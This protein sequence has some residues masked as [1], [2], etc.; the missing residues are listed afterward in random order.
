MGDV[1]WYL[2][3]LVLLAGFVYYVAWV[4]PRRLCIRKFEHPVRGVKKPIR[5]VAIGDL[6]PNQWHWPA[7]RLAEAFDQARSYDPDLVVWLG[8]YY[9]SLTGT[10]S[11]ILE[12]LPRLRRWIVQK[13]PVMEEIAYEM[14][15]LKP[16]LGA[17]SVLGNHDWGWSG[18]LTRESLE[19]HGIPVLID[20]IVVIDDEQ[21]DQKLQI[22]GY[23]DVSSDRTPNY[24]DLLEKLDPDLPQIA[25]AHSP[26]TFALSLNTPSLMLCGHTH[27]GQIWPF[28]Y[29]VRLRYPFLA[30]RY[31]V[32]DMSLIVCRGTGT[33][34]PR[35]RLWYPGEILQIILRSG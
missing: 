13:M 28:G 27:G 11:H 31:E 35:M 24:R 7:E 34:G 26:D 23:D 33:W 10:T 19:A 21:N 22:L 12:R 5:L 15:Q 29:L 9:N 17:V 16:R 32:D 3:L 8:D 2:F 30:G 1:L 18:D 25:I 4:E 20:D 6:Q 14:A